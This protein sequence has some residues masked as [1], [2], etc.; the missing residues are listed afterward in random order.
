MLSDLIWS[1]CRSRSISVITQPTASM[2]ADAMRRLA[3]DDLFF[4]QLGLIQRK[5]ATEI[6]RGNS[7]AAGEVAVA[8]FLGRLP[9]ILTNA[10]QRAINDVSADLSGS[11][12]MQ[13]LVQGDVG[14]GKTVVAAAAALQATRAGFQT[15][16]M[17]PTEILAGQL[18]TTLG[19]LYESLG[20]RC[21]HRRAPDR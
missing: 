16:V 6:L 10:Q 14:S 15:A 7:L 18:R 5:R 8:G 17:A 3:F 4:L 12:V 9:F 11:R 2:L 20:R 21:S 19:Q 13:R 1:N